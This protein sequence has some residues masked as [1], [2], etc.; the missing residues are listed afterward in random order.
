MMQ[1]P[2]TQSMTQASLVDESAVIVRI[3]H[4]EQT[5][6]TEL[7]DRY[8]RVLYSLAY[9]ILGSPEE[10]EEVVLDVFAQVWKNAASYSHHRGRVDSW[11][12][13]M[14]R[15]RA[16]D[17]IRRRKRQLRS[18]QAI[19]LETKGCSTEDP[20]EEVFITQRR[21][22][23]LMALAQLPSQQREALE[24]AYFNGLTHAEI[25]AQ[26]NIPLGTIK[27]RLRLGL[28]KLRE[29]LTPE[30]ASP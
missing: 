12:F 20:V 10:A 27:T 11:L 2:V 16:L 25:A 17:R 24:L 18:I 9:R 28:A 29:I 30:L 3:A 6:L 22:Q 13:M 4:Q 26:T 15:S 14:T 23:I 7:Y 21:V 5:A 8:G 1:V 19:S